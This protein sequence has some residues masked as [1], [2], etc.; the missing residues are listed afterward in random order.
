MKIILFGASGMIGQGVLRECLRDPE[1]THVL[2]VGRSP[3]GKP[4]S[5]FHELIHN[6][7]FQLGPIEA[8]FEGYDA[9]I[10]CLGVSAAGL[11]EQEYH[12]MTYN[13]T[14]AVAQSLVK[15]NPA[16]TF[17]YI[18]AQGADSSER[19]A[20]MWARVK[21]KTENALL[22]LPFKAAY[23][24]RPGL[25]QPLHGIQSRTAIYR[26]FYKLT[27]PLLP[28]LLRFPKYVTTTERLG[29]AMLL[30][31]KRGAPKKILESSDIN[32]LR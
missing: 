11:S 20:L 30:A 2:S 16:M 29:R 8:S 18:S 3:L 31:A 5:K 15:R 9:C 23:M 1:V 13:L 4:Q 17:V 32:A 12:R 27:A 7:L 21:G 10:F 24:F 19:G 22:R 25:I 28:L 6:D 14:L 26:F